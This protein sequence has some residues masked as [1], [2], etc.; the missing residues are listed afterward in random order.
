[1]AEKIGGALA[2]ALPCMRITDGYG[3]PALGQAREL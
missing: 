3:G 2:V 1:M